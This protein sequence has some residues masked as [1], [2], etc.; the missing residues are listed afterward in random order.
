VTASAGSLRER[1]KARLRVEL[2]RAAVELFQQQG[3][4]ATTVEQIAARAETSPSTFFRYFG[5][6]EDVLFGD[7]PERLATL[8]TE[9]AAARGQGRA[10]DAV[11]R[12]LVDQ[13]VGFTNFDD[14]QL[15]ADCAEL[16]FSE[17][18]PRRRYVEIVLEWE[19]V[20]S[21]FLG[22]EWG[23]PADSVRCR[24]TAMAVIAAVR[25]SLER[26]A[27]GVDAARAALWEGFRLLDDGLNP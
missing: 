10:L 22:T 1:K 4:D 9:L 21:E 26:G 24:V 13:I 2:T 20:I 5:T 27:G 15:E 8:R 3:F 6:K 16:W 7:T 23:L 18:G 19:H 14:A 11:Q 25:V 17:P 12:T